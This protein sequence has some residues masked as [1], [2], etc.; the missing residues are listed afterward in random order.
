VLRDRDLTEVGYNFGWWGRWQSHVGG[1]DV[2]SQ[3][4]RFGHHLIHDD[5]VHGALEVSLNLKKNRGGLN[6]SALLKILA[7]EGHVDDTILLFGIE[8]GEALLGHEVDEEIVADLGV[9]VYALAVCLGDSLSEDSW[10]LRVEE[11]VDPGELGVLLETVP[12]ASVDLAL[13][14]VRVYEDWLPFAA[15]IFILKEAFAGDRR[16]VAL[17]IEPNEIHSS[18]RRQSYSVSSKGS[19]GSQSDG[20]E[21]ALR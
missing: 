20:F 2:L 19:S 4:F 10:V 5:L 7:G 6:W 16:K 9:G 12:V 17:G 21:G 8:L 11:Q 14:V 3:L 13:T 18:G 1:N 15:A